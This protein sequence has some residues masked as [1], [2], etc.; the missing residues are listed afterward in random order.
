[1]GE[2]L[3]DTGKSKKKHPIHGVA[4]WEGWE[5]RGEGAGKVREDGKGHSKKW[6]LEV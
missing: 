5:R 3:E 2:E 4:I 1:M 6:C